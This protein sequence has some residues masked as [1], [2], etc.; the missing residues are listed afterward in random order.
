[1]RTFGRALELGLNGIEIDIHMM[2]DGEIMVL[3]G[4][5]GK[6]SEDFPEHGV[7]ADDYIASID[8][9][10]MSKCRLHGEW[11]PFL[12]EVI[13]LCIDTNTKLNIDCKTIDIEIV[14]P[15]HEMVTE[16]T[17]KNGCSIS[18]YSSE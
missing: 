2:S 10:T 13:E 16:H 11:V 6:V 8:S 5:H 15:L 12:H 3:H 9:R 18:F 17:F 7:S 14:E 4:S 1:M